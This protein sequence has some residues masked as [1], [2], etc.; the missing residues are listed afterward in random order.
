MF[1]CAVLFLS[2]VLNRSV[3][4]DVLIDNTIEFALIVH[5]L[6]VEVLSVF[7]QYF[8]FSVVVFFCDFNVFYENKFTTLKITNSSLTGET[9]SCQN[10][11]SSGVPFILYFSCYAYL[12]FF[13]F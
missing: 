4:S 12:D 1:L 3:S 11:L 13:C 6:F 8:C 5:F 10:C 7:F 2:A 9:V